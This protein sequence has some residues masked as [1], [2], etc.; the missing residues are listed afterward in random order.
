MTKI[1]MDAIIS[2]PCVYLKKILRNGMNLIKLL[3]S[4][5]AYYSYAHSLPGVVDYF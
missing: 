3:F 5:H 2:V 1:V 4:L